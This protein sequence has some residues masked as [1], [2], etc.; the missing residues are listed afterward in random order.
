MMQIFCLVHGP[1]NV[2]GALNR[3]KFDKKKRGKQV[4]IPEHQKKRGRK[5][6]IVHRQSNSASTLRSASHLAA[7]S[8]ASTMRPSP[9]ILAASRILRGYRFDPA[10][11]AAS[12][13]WRL[14]G[15]INGPRVPKPLPSPQLGGFGPNSSVL[16]GNGATFG[17]LSSFLPDFACPPQGAR[18]PRDLV[19]CAYRIH[20]ICKNVVICLRI[21][22]VVSWLMLI[23][24]PSNL[25]KHKTKCNKH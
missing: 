13:Y 11:T 3:H 25:S 10:P 9:R 14:S 5:D 23:F 8:P 16:R 21:Y 12:G 6:S 4:K 22:A 19:I 20:D 17:R 18:L 24:L 7:A 15:A 1:I 2:S